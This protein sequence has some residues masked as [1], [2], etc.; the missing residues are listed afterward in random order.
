[1]TL[2]SDV[3]WLLST[4]TLVSILFILA[5]IFKVLQ[6][7]FLPRL[8]EFKWCVKARKLIENNAMQLALLVAIVAMSGSLFFS[9]VALYEPCKLCWLQRIFMYPL[10]A[11]LAVALWKKDNEV[12]RYTLALAVPGMILAGYHYLT[13]IGIKISSACA[14]NGGVDCTVKIFTSY[15]LI[16]I[17]LMAFTAFALIIIFALINKSKYPHN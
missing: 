1:M 13:Q 5:V 2:V 7:K 10:V 4:I 15:G 8:K 12:W 6:K 17:P 3:R 16:T 14:A 9:D 11:I